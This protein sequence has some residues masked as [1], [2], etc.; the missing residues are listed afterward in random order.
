MKRMKV[1][2]FVLVLLS[3]LLTQC[4]AP[5]A[6]VASTPQT[7]EKIVTQEVEK[8][9]TVEVSKNVEVTP[10]PK[11]QTQAEIDT[12]W[13]QY[14]GKGLSINFL[15]EDTPPTAAIVNHLKEFE[16]LTGIKVNLTT[17]NLAD[18]GTKVLLDFS[19][20]TGDIQ[21]IYADPFIMLAPLYGHF[22]GLDKFINDPT[23]P[24][25]PNGIEDFDKMNLEVSGY[26]ID[27]N[28]LLAIPY[29]A[30]TILLTYRTDIFDNPEYKKMFMDEKK[31]DWTPGPN[32]TWEQYAE[33]AEW[34]NKKVADGT[35]KGVKYGTGHQAKQYE[36]ADVRFQRCAAGVRRELLCQPGFCHLGHLNPWRRHAGYAGSHQ[37]G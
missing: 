18:V 7:V 21:V 13:K 26:M 33:I 34:I 15:S 1:F 2:P 35:I 3:L 16:D 11:V 29:D 6:P 9:V 36:L 28:K 30:P 10:T 22:I 25:V 14:Q 37:G 17:T 8:L 32:I 20:G 24:P 19:A 31:Y 4:G 23:L 12:L 5:A 27:K